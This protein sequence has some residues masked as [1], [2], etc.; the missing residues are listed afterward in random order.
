ML[1]QVSFDLP[2]VGFDLLHVSFFDGSPTQPAFEEKSGWNIRDPQ[3]IQSGTQ[4]LGLELRPLEED[5]RS[6]PTCDAQ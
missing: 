2:E 6:G 3:A 4:F 1:W 5:E